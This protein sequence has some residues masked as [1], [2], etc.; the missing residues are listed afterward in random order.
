MANEKM[1]NLKETNK[2]NM[3]QLDEVAGGGAPSGYGNGYTGWANSSRFL[4]VLLGGA[5]CDR[6]GSFK[7]GFHSEEIISAWTKVGV[8]LTNENGMVYKIN[9][10]KVSA[11]RAFE[12]AMNVTGRHLK[13]EDW[14]W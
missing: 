1:E 5:V 14:C 8:E 2:D 13:P 6:Y 9:G 11:Q 4:N 10:K 12:H 7:A 3:V